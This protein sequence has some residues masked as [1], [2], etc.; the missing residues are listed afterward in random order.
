M[1]PAMGKKQI[2]YGKKEKKKSK[3]HLTI[4]A[5]DPQHNTKT[6]FIVNRWK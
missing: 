4:C 5:I 3:F 6:Y 2:F 1:R